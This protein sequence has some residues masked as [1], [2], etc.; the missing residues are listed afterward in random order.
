MPCSRRSRF[1]RGQARVCRSVCGLAVHPAPD[2]V[3]AHTDDPG[4]SPATPDRQRAARSVR[5]HHRRRAEQPSLC[6]R[7]RV[8]TV[9]SGPMSEAS[10]PAGRARVSGIANMVTAVPLPLHCSAVRARPRHPATS[11]PAGVLKPAAYTAGRGRQPTRRSGRSTRTASTAGTG[12]P[13]YRLGNT[14]GTDRRR[15]S[16][17][18]SRTGRTRRPLH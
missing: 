15:D 4:V 9:A 13:G 16:R 12:K 18:R 11:S 7:N 3:S 14:P 1:P 8:C 5:R 2:P 6:R 10:P 17:G